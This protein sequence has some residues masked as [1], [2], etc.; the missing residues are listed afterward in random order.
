MQR[1]PAPELSRLITVRLSL[2]KL[3]VRL[4]KCS[5]SLKSIFETSPASFIA[6]CP[7]SFFLLP[8][9]VTTS[10]SPTQSR[11]H[12]LSAN[13]CTRESPFFLNRNDVFT[14]KLIPLL[15]I[16]VK[17]LSAPFVIRRK[18]HSGTPDVTVVVLMELVL[19]KC[20]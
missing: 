7:H 1:G 15:L 3:P 8:P 17:L 13:V 5:L 12:F 11:L 6:H 2:A 4:T 14:L 20:T 19:R 9:P 18:R 16:D 10:R